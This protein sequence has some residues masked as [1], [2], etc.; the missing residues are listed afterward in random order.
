MHVTIRRIGNCQAI[1][2]P[3]QLLDKLG[4]D[5]EAGAELTIDGKSL[6]LRKPAKP[7]RAGWADAAL[8][9]AAAGDDGLVMGEF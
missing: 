3:K 5:I 1:L 9:I 7:L 6:V 8:A 2:I 4:F